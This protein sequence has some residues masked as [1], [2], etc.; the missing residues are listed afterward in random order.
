MAR[1]NR[2]LLAD[3]SVT[4]AIW[5]TANRLCSLN[6]ATCL[7]DLG[8]SSYGAIHGQAESKGNLVEMPPL[9]E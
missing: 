7:L 2:F 8:E 1:P 9:T 5:L 6:T 4:S 3:H